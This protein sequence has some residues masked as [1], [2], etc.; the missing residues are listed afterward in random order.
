MGHY[1]AALR[2]H[3]LRGLDFRA[4][5]FYAPFLTAVRGATPVWGGFFQWIQGLRLI[6]FRDLGFGFWGFPGLGYPEQK[7]AL[8]A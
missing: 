7:K 4:L 1:G 8:Q 5:G 3:E 6:G 2:V